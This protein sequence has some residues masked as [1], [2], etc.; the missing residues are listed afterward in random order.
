MAIAVEIARNLEETLF[1]E[2]HFL[3]KIKQQV[4]FIHTNKS[5]RKENKHFVE[6]QC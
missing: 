4:F 3:W 1:D 6:C 5:I 2:Q